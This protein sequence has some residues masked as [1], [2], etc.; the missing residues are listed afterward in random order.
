MRDKKNRVADASGTVRDSKKAL[1]DE[2]DARLTKAL[3]DNLAR[4]K[5]QI[6]AR[7]EADSAQDGDI[8]DL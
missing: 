2:R 4:R 3:R 1:R 7:A 8:T 6:R 5:S